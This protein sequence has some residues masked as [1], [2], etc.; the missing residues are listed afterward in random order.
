MKILHNGTLNKFI[1]SAFKYNCTVLMES[2]HVK[3]TLSSRLDFEFRE[4]GKGLTG[5]AKDRFQKTHVVFFMGQHGI[6]H[7][8]SSGPLCIK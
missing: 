6:A 7:G 8:T 5:S 1:P 2:P 4:H 3:Q